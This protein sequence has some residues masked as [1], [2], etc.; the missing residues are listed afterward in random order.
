MRSGPLALAIW[1]ASF[2]LCLVGLGL[3]ATSFGTPLPDSWGFRGFT[4][5]FAMTFGS[6]GALIVRRHPAHAVGWLLLFGGALSAVQ[7]FA[8]EYLIAG[9]VTWPGLPAASW[10]GWLNVWIWSFTVL[11]VAVLA[12]LY[13]PDGRLPSPGW[14]PMLPLTAASAVVT[15]AGA[16]LAPDQLSTN[17]H[18]FPPPYD[19]RQLAPVV[20]DNARLLLVIGFAIA[21][22]LAVASTVSVGRRFRQARGTERQ[23]IKW[24]AYAATILGAAVAVNAVVQTRYLTDL[25]PDLP[26]WILKLPEVFLILSMAILPL[27]IGVAILRYRLYDIDVLIQRTLVYGGVSVVLAGTYAVGVLVLQALL[28]PITGGSQLSVAISTLLVVALFQP[29]RGRFQDA[30]D[31]RFYRTRYNAARTIDAFAARLRDEIDLSTLEREVLAVV[32]RTVKPVRASLWLRER[33]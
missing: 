31:R 3:L 18:R 10:I 16:A 26:D 22:V 4:A 29:I 19:V 6:V 7:L 12:V 24:F 15:A 14:W 13:F 8:D 5:L 23:Q 21:S 32:D 30:V 2:A 17:M 1:T 28:R 33:S 9:F 20:V 27:A 25:A 11:S